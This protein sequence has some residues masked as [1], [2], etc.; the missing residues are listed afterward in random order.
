MTA[1]PPPGRSDLCNAGSAL[2]VA[3][4]AAGATITDIQVAYAAAITTVRAMADSTSYLTGSDGETSTPS[5]HGFDYRPAGQL[6]AVDP[7]GLSD[8]TVLTYAICGKPVRVW[9]DKPFDP[10]ADGCHDECVGR[11]MHENG[12]K[13]S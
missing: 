4:S 5:E 9:H 13:S 7:S 1:V 6:H 3:K 12:A 10:A 8:Q 2:L 11:A